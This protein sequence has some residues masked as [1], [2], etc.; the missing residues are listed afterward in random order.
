MMDRCVGYEANLDTTAK[1]LPCM[2]TSVVYGHTASRGL[3]LNRW[4]FGLDTGCVSCIRVPRTNRSLI[5]HCSGLWS[6]VDGTGFGPPSPPY[7]LVTTRRGRCRG[8]LCTHSCGRN[9]G[10][11]LPVT[12]T[13]DQVRGRWSSHQGFHRGGRLF[14]LESH[15]TLH[16]HLLFGQNPSFSVASRR[17]SAFVFH[18]ALSRLFILIRAM[19]SC[20]P[21]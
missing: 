6:Y 7:L 13:Q 9:P 1:G 10:S 4:T 21:S 8:Y 5:I 19:V 3:D 12:K 11:T 17:C 14:G 2:P 20:P 15:I 18:L 16:L